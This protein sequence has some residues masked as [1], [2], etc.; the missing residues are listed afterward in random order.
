MPPALSGPRNGGMT[1]QRPETGSV[2]MEIEC[3]FY[4]NGRRCVLDL[5]LRTFA[6][7]PNRGACLVTRGPTV[8]LKLPRS[9]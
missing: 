1:L 6:V 2:T 9:P 7:C 5:N 8:E 4:W 3:P